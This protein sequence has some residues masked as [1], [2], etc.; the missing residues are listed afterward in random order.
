[1]ILNAIFPLCN[2]QTLYEHQSMEKPCWEDPVGLETINTIVKKIIP[3]WTNG[4]HMVQLK[5]FQL[6]LIDKT[7]S[8]ALQL[9]MGKWQPFLLVFGSPVS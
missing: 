9:E 3:L 7:F 6:S 8:A 4:L 2:L 1:M 5:L